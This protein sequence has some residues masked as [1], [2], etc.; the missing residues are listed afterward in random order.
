VKFNLP[1]MPMPLKTMS[2][3]TYCISSK[4]SE[5]FEVLE[6]TF[7]TAYWTLKSQSIAIK[8]L[9]SGNGVRILFSSLRRS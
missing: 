7:V 6:R 9:R 5:G 1:K 3:S 4:A 2:L 8:I